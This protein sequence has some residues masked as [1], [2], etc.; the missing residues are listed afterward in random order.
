MSTYFGYGVASDGSLTV[1]PSDNSNSPGLT[2]WNRVT[3]IACP[4]SGNFN[5]DEIAHWCRYTTP[6]ATVRCAIYNAAGT[7]L[8]AYG[9]AAASAGISTAG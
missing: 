9:T 3:T 2:F 8:I 7:T 6:G 4:G 1:S 5:I